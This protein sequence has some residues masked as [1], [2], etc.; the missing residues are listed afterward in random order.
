MGG[1]TNTGHMITSGL[2]GAAKQF[3]S[4]GYIVHEHNAQCTLADT[5]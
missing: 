4:S 1:D 2:K 5:H 3:K